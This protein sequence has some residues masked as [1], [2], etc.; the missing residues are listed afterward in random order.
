MTDSLYVD[1]IIH[2]VEKLDTEKQRQV[3]EYA[4]SLSKPKGI[5][6]RELIQL[7]HELN[8]DPQDLV[9][10]QQ[11][12]EEECEQLEDFPEVDLDG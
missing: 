5:S 6:G 11:A 7:A 12:I 1:Q 9:E 10:M 3:L 8:F 2:Y 4:Q